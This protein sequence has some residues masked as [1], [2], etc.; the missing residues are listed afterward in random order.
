MPKVVKYKNSLAQVNM[1]LNTTFTNVLALI[2]E[3]TETLML[4]LCDVLTGK[5]GLKV[6]NSIPE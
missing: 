6:E 3:N 2:P 4:Y 5:R 1:L